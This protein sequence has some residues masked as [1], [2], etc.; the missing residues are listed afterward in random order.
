MMNSEY[1]QREQSLGRLLEQ[2]LFFYGKV[3]D[4]FNFMVNEHMSMEAMQSSFNAFGSTASST[5]VILDPLNP[6]NNIG[7]STYNIEYIKAQ[8]ALAYDRLILLQNEFIQ[9][10]EKRKDMNILQEVL[11][12]P[13]FK[14][15][16]YQNY[17]GSAVSVG[18]NEN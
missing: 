6:A 15:K 14:M 13:D 2:F 7:K 11:Q 3:F 8:F 9:N 12:I 18:S 17:E 16:M 10:E 1:E 4:P 5:L